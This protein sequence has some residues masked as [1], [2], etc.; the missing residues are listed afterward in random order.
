[1]S[2][3]V[4]IRQEIPSLV[5]EFFDRTAKPVALVAGTVDANGRAVT[6][7]GRLAVQPPEDAMF[8]IGSVTKA[9]TS[10]LLADMAGC[11]EVALED[12]VARYLPAGTSVP[13]RG[14]RQIT[15]LDLAMHVSGLPRL[16]GNLALWLHARNPYAHYDAARL[17]HFLARCEL[18]FE[19]GQT[20]V[21]SN[22]GAGLLGHALALRAGMTYERL[23]RERILAPLGME[24]TG[25][26][27]SEEQRKRFV[28]GYNGWLWRVDPWGFDVLAGCGALRSTAGD[29]LTFLAA[30]LEPD[31]SPLGAAMRRMLSVRR[32]TGI[33]NVDIAMGW[34]VFT[35][36]GV[37]WHHGGTFASRSFAAFDPEKR[38]GVV[39]LSNYGGELYPHVREI[40]MRV[41]GRSS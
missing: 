9:F 30:N 15:L 4:S 25:I 23:V 41:L 39:V 31:T 14:R 3:Q 24:S 20:Y 27:L 16:P 8:E 17:Y 13:R 11:G 7:I 33:A 22:L 2:P 35:P 18:Q 34:H 21:Y 1:M 10:L 38:K 29:L 19:I 5:G 28:T 36:S 6:C 37:V 32:P 40:G 12:P 26:A